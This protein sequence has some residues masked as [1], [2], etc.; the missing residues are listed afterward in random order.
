MGVQVSQFAEY[1]INGLGFS[2]N[3]YH[4]LDAA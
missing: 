1:M 2:E 3:Q 4:S